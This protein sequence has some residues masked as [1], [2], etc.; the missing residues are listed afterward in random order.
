MFFSISSLVAASL[1]LVAS[2]SPVEQSA[3]DALGG[4]AADDVWSPHIL[5]P[6]A[7][8][9]W[10]I[11]QSVNVTWDTSD[12]PPVISNGASVVLRKE[13]LPLTLIDDF[14]LRAGFVTVTVPNVAPAN[15][16]SIVLFGDSGNDSEDFTITN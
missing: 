11:G 4:R 16:Y 1:A 8:T 12:A 15:D 10:V 3:R 2:A 5:T 9:V 14:D 13:V 6:N 7:G